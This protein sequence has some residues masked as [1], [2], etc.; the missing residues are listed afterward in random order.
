MQYDIIVILGI[1]L[2]VQQTELFGIGPM[3]VCNVPL[4]KVVIYI[5]PGNDLRED[6]LFYALCR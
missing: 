5:A 4:Q 6:I 2:D 3:E 1:E